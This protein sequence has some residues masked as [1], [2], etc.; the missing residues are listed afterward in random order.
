MGKLIDVPEGDVLLHAGDLTF[1]G[2]E[3]EAK[4]ALKWLQSLRD[5]FRHIL[6]TPG[7]HDFYFDKRIKHGHTFRSWRITRHFSIETMLEH[8]APDVQ[9]LVDRAV[10]IDGIK[11]YGSPWQQ[12]FYDWA[13][14]FPVFAVEERQWPLSPLVK[15]DYEAAKACWAKI[16]DDTQVLLTHA[17]PFGL[18][19]AI[20]SKWDKGD[21]RCGCPELRKRLGELKKLRLHVFGHIHEGYGKETWETLDMDTKEKSDLTFVNAAINTREYQP[22]NPPIVVD[23]D[24][25]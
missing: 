1:R 13:F 20:G 2:T 15:H 17:P 24:F 8:Y 9:L 25:G 22:T 21:D 18:L 6:V 3:S 16:P 12:W 14:N 10:E 4:A 19:D 7:N 5:R 11:V 23:V